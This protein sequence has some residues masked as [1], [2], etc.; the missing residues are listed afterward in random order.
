MLRITAELPKMDGT[1]A[2][3]IVYDIV[4]QCFGHESFASSVPEPAIGP[5]TERTS[6]VEARGRSVL[7]PEKPRI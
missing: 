4:T 2:T 6:T 7:L 5:T 3:Y 1:I